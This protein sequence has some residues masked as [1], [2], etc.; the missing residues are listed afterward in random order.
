M[1]NAERHPQVPYNVKGEGFK[2]SLI[3]LKYFQFCQ[4]SLNSYSTKINTLCDIKH[5]TYLPSSNQRNRVEFRCLICVIGHT[6][7]FSLDALTTSLLTSIPEYYRL[8]R[9]L[10]ESRE[11]VSRSNTPR[12]CPCAHPTSILSTANPG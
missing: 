9:H 3:Q 5:R 1:E 12:W 6:H 4:I 2:I 7:L 10:S 11:G 8:Q